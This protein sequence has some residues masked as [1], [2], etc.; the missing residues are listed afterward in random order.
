[1]SR[2]L[3]IH[4]REVIDSR[5]NP[6]VEVEVISEY[7]FGRAIVPSGAS[8]GELEANEMRDG[9]KSRFSG[10]GVLKA[11]KNVNE[12]IAPAIIKEGFLVDEQK[13]VDAFMIK[14]DG[15]KNKSSLGANAILGVSLAMAH[16]AADELGVPL[17]RYL[18]G[19]NAHEL[20]VPMMNIINGGAHAENIVDLQEFMIMPVGASSIKEA[21]RMGAETYHC[22]KKV[23]VN[24]GYAVGVGDEGGFAPDCKSIEEVLDCICQAIKDAGYKPSRT[25]KKAIGIALDAAASELYTKD[26][27]Y[28]FKKL[29]KSKNENIVKTTDE[30]IEMYANLANKY[31]ILSIEDGLGEHDWEGMAK[32]TAKIGHKVQIVGDDTFVTNPMII[33]KGIKNKTANSVLIKVNQIGTLSEAMEA[34]QM[35]QKAG[36]TAVVSH[37]SGESE[38]AT[39]ADLSVA[40]N[41]GQIKTGSMSR[42]DRIAKY[43]QLIRIEEEL[44]GISKYSGSK[45]FYNLKDSDKI[46]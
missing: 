10:K 23:L 43:N 3:D 42:T 13:L 5:G 28:H 11:V 12:I 9:D 14:L 30:M 4:A 45:T 7:G 39:I 33:A 1:M 6:T 8:T 17:Y 25:G 44:E 29:S 41:T 20:P 36:W 27:T 24:K 2:I 34:I 26:K 16:A 15:T 35:T 38:D 32:L 46:N 21:I 22:L 31:P 19:T 40:L 37:R 18:G